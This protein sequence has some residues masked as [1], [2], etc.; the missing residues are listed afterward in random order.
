MGRIKG[1]Q[2][3]REDEGVSGRV[4]FQ[5]G[6]QKTGD[7]ESTSRTTMMM[8]Y[9]TANANA[10]LATTVLVAL[11][12]SQLARADPD[13]SAPIVSTTAGKVQGEVVD[14][15]YTFKGIPF[16]ADTSGPNRWLAPKDPEPWSDVRN[17]TT[18]M[19][20]C[21]Q[22]VSNGTTWSDLENMIGMSMPSLNNPAPGI[23]EDCLGLNVYTPAL[24]EKLPVMVWIHGGSLTNGAGSMY[25]GEILANAG[26][27][28]VVTIN[29]RLGFLGYIAH[30]ELNGTNFGL[31]D[32]IKA[33]EWV[34]EN[35]ENFGGDPSKVTIFGESAGGASVL[36][37]MVSPLSEGLFQRVISESAG[38]MES[39]NV[40]VSEGGKL[41][42][43]VGVQLGLPAGAG[44]LEKMR[45]VSAKDLIQA[46]LNMSA[47]DGI[48]VNLFVDGESLPQCIWCAFA[49][50]EQGSSVHRNVDLMIGTNQ[51]E[52]SLFWLLDPSNTGVFPNTTD[53]YKASVEKIY[54]PE[55]AKE[56]LSLFPGSPDALAESNALQTAIWFGASSDFVANRNRIIGNPTFLYYFTQ[57]PNTTEGQQLGAFHGMDVLYLFFDDSTPEFSLTK[58]MQVYWTNFAKSG[59][60]NNGGSGSD[61]TLPEWKAY[62][63]ASPS[64]QVLS[65]AETGSEPVPED[66]QALYSVTNTLYP[67]VLPAMQDGKNFYNSSA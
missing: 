8:R 62:D 33:L 57:K 53:A 4:T 3:A 16:A 65:E 25:P 21:P 32:Q 36:A 47:S 39:P 14:G 17:A 22:T 54:G 28:I 67:N 43:A 12:A 63:D 59:D 56:V 48:V 23:S 64:W 18:F 10:I 19:D 41:G 7:R 20:W 60:P 5:R 31:L 52:T 49:E 42:V 11:L 61:E 35:I 38:I 34:S 15:I 45:A 46:E 50:D 2:R 29:Y 26:N 13:A 9:A 40:T 6:K 51:N 27:V 37:L 44:Q 66:M 30:P 55:N 58:N 1:P 24:D